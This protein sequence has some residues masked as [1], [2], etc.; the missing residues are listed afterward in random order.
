M[1]PPTAEPSPELRRGR[2]LFEQKTWADAHDA[3]LLADQLEPLAVEDLWR[4]VW[5]P[6]GRGRS[7]NR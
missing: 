6:G 3:L 7:K 5:Y 2:E 4:L 1:A